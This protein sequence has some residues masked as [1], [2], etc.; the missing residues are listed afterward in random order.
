M[1]GTIQEAGAINDWRVADLASI[2]LPDALVNIGKHYVRLDSLQICGDTELLNV[3]IGNAGGA[4]SFLMVIAPGM[5][6]KCARRNASA[7]AS[8]DSDWQTVLANMLHKWLK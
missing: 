6:Q 7:R 5:G 1:I 4:L 2:L 8:D 3:E